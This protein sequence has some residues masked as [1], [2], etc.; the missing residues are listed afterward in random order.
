MNF[1]K[2]LLRNRLDV[3]LEACVMMYAQN[4][5]TT[6]YF[7]YEELEKALAAS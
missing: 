5:F 4:M 3:N 1:I 7:L 2:N 6:A